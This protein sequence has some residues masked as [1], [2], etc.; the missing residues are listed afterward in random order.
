MAPILPPASTDRARRHAGTAVFRCDAGPGIGAGHVHRCLAIAAAL[1]RLGWRCRFVVG[2]DTPS[3]VPALAAD[4]HPVT[5]VA[6]AAAE[7]AALF[8]AGADLL[9]LDHYGRDAAFSGPWRRGG[10]RVLAL[11]DAPA[12]AQ[13]CDILLDATPGRVPS[14]YAGLLPPDCR[15]MLGPAF[16]PLHADFRRLRG[17]TLARRS[18]EVRR[19]LVAV[20]GADGTA[21]TASAARAAASALPD[22]A[23]DV[24]AGGGAPSLAGIRDAVATIGPR[25]RLHV[26]TPRMAE[27]IAA[28]DL[29]VGA[30]GVSAW[31]R[32]A[33]GLPALVFSA[34]ANQK[35]NAAALAATGAAEVLGTPEAWNADGLAA[36]IA[37]LA[38]DATR[39]RSMS[40]AA[41]VLTDG[42]GA[43]R[44][45]L[46]LA[47]EIALADGGIVA[48]RPAGEA[49]TEMLL[50][51]QAEPGA[52]RF[53]R[54]PTVPDAEAH[55]RWFAHRLADAAGLTAVV[56]VDRAGAGTVRLDIHP[57]GREV[58]VMVGAAWRG[59]GV[60]TAALALLRRAAPRLDLW[61]E[62][63]PGNAASQRLFASAGYR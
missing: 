43:L 53:A 36:R 8:A 32:C 31:E 11:D 15:A 13:D 24:V 12:R 55:A 39:L 52:R 35:A 44:A 3:A 46:A 21:A 57:H 41:A 48:L 17:P 45:A 4:A 59:R 28:A 23:I 19:V 16:A 50:S 5:A 62:I 58:A 54:D 27:L 7:H 30:A 9:V 29:A 38:G 60:A 63:L 40:A 20:G 26:D 61:A 47:G 25:C 1:A 34:A 6:D 14:D 49:D 37:A 42:A 18:T 2:P 56:T 22:A 33:L 10:M 51:W